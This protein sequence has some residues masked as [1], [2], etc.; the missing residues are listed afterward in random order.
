MTEWRRATPDDVVALR[1]LERIASQTGLAHVFGD[2]PYP[3][4]DV[5]AR[6]ALLL[7]DPTVVVDVVDDDRGLAALAAH[8]GSTLRHLA[9]RPDLW[10]TGLGRAGFARA[11]AA[12]ARRLWVL[13]DNAKARALYE[14]LGWTPSGATQDCPW[15]PYPTELE[16]VAAPDDEQQPPAVVE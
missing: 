2:L 4:D 10:G 13:E 11:E 15:P 8:D 6:W 1:D 5:L 3:D 7:D 14:S 12:G 9:V 16:Y